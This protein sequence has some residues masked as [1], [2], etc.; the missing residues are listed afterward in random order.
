M[1]VGAFNQEKALVGAFS[2]I[3][4]LHRLIDLRHYSCPARPSSRQHRSWGRRA[5]SS[6]TPWFSPRLQGW[7]FVST[8]CSCSPWSRGS[9]VWGGAGPPCFCRT[10]GSTAASAGETPGCRGSCSER[11]CCWRTGRQPGRGWRSSWRSLQLKKIWLWQNDRL[12]YFMWLLVNWYFTSLSWH[13][14]KH[15]WKIVC[16]DVEMFQCSS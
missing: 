15:L 1:L 7:R 3:V 8:R 16:V 10:P 14:L 4:Q 2:V 6:G 9:R 13:I 5:W 11:H 12:L